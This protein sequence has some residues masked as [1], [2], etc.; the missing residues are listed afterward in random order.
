MI[1]FYSFPWVLLL[2]LFMGG[3]SDYSHLNRDLDNYRPPAYTLL[4]PSEK[5]EKPEGPAVTDF[6]REKKQIEKE[7]VK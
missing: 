1:K 5:P 4:S 3:C 2:L 6:E 7:G